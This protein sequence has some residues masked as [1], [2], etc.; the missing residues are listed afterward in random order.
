MPGTFIQLD[1]VAGRYEKK[2]GGFDATD[3]YDQERTKSNGVAVLGGVWPKYYTPVEGSNLERDIVKGMGRA[4][5]I[6]VTGEGTGIETPMDKITRFRRI[7]GGFP[8]YIG[9][10]LNHSNAY[11]QM[12][13]GDG[14]IV[15]S[16]LKRDNNTKY[17][18]ERARV[19]DLVS[20]FRE[21]RK[22]KK[23]QEPVSDGPI[24]V[25]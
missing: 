5:A 18:V 14:A 21:V 6:V 20:I 25:Q 8:L 11:E 10:G 7:L 17:E 24:I 12:Q 13:V 9:A 23:K 15:G 1:Y 19:K 4:D 3:S 22:E 2:A 16:C